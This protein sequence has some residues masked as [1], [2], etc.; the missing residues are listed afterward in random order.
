M[1]KSTLQGRKKLT[2][3]IYSPSGAKM[4]QISFFVCPWAAR[5]FVDMFANMDG[6]YLGAIRSLLC[7][8]GNWLNSS[9]TRRL[10]KYYFA[11][12]DLYGRNKIARAFLGCAPQKLAGRYYQFINEQGVWGVLAPSPA[13]AYMCFKASHSDDNYV[14]DYLVSRETIRAG[15]FEATRKRDPHNIGYMRVIPG[16]REERN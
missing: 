5:R 13:A 2:I 1:R 8:W 12:R 14:W 6:D 16:G 7:F 11:V 9:A 4:S 3:A 10:T 15:F